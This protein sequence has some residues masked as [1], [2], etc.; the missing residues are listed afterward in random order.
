MWILSEGVTIKPMNWTGKWI[1]PAYDP[2]TDV[3]I[4][5]F[6]RRFRLDAVPASLPVHV[7]AD[8]RYKLLVNGQ[9]VSLGP[10]RG[11]LEHWYFDTIDLAPYLKPGD[12]TILAV[13]WNFAY[14]APM[15][16]ITFRTGFLLDD[17]DHGL[18]TPDHWEVARIKGWDFEMMSRGARVFYIDIGPGEIVDGREL[19]D[20]TAL[21]ENVAQ[22]WTAPNTVRGA[23]SRGATYE[24]AWAL[25]PRS[26]PPVRY[27]EVEHHPVVRHGFL[28]DTGGTDR[29]P[30]A[31]GHAIQPGA[32]TVLDFKEL[33]CAYPRI[34]LRG[35]AGTVVT[36]TYAEAM[37]LPDG[38]KG[39]RNDVAGKEMRGVQDKVV[40]GSGPTVFEPLWFRPFRYMSF[41]VSE[42]SE[43]VVLEGL[44]IAETGY[45]YAVDSL[46]EADDPHVAPIWDVS[47]RTAKRCA[48]ETYYDC[49]YYEQLQYGGDTRIQTMIHYYVSRD[50]ALPRNA[51]QQFRWS[52]LDNGLTESRYP[53][54]M[55]QT[56]PPF[57]LW[58]IQMQHDALMYDRGPALTQADHE[59]NERI[60][61]TYQGIVDG[62]VEPFWQFGDWVHA[63]RDGVPPGGAASTMHRLTLLLARLAVADLA[64]QIDPRAA[65]RLGQDAKTALRKE[66]TL[67]AGLVAHRED[68]QWHP[69]EHS[70]ALY[71]L[72]QRW[73]GMKV[74]PWPAPELDASKA[75]RCTYYFS[76]YKHQAMLPA[77]YLSELGEWKA[78]IE[79]GLTTFAENPPPTRSDCHAWSAHP[80]LGFFQIVAGVTS[81]S[82]GWTRCRIEPRPG[83]LERFHA[84]IAH[85]DGDMTVSYE[86]GRLKIDTPIPATLV[87]KG[88]SQQLA[89][90]QFGT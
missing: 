71:R 75:D 47:L 67:R 36:V 59:A 1:G 51:V 10:Q 14:W 66:Y 68:A 2:K 11:D 9:P 58:W 63:W 85:P 43:P 35:P 44:R 65:A 52:L 17:A 69:S 38:S 79:D 73:V 26:I 74:S 42:S 81:E 29:E 23:A 27:E 46:F 37:W 24:P 39:H 83:S 15:A 7:S 22:S 13:V 53:N 8:N 54:R 82:P 19:P 5:A 28:G 25:I 56:I 12:N 30:L 49:P 61:T 90:G 20:W 48:G 33:L 78:M 77:D 62:K 45:P 86:D 16:Q 76:H 34:A 6:R 32:M 31:P 55:T 84:R 87:W 41:E 4:F 50:R 21:G 70:E 3:G 57:S 72:A 40:L 60:L 89:P 18:S 88:K 80:A 64:A